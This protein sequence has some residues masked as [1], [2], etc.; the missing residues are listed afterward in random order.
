MSTPWRTSLLRLLD[1][2]PATAAEHSKD[3][4]HWQFT[5]EDARGIC[6]DYPDIDDADCQLPVDCSG[7]WEKIEKSAA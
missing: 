4:P 3:K 5:A 6:I 1:K 2:L 7:F